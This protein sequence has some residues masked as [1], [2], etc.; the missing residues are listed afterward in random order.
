MDWIWSEYTTSPD[1]AAGMQSLNQMCSA[2]TKHVLLPTHI[3]LLRVLINVVPQL[4]HFLNLA[5]RDAGLS[6]VQDFCQTELQLL[7][8]STGSDVATQ[9]QIVWN[10]IHL[11]DKVYIAMVDMKSLWNRHLIHILGRERPLQMRQIVMLLPPSLRIKL[12]ANFLRSYGILVLLPAANAQE[13]EHQ[14]IRHLDC[15]ARMCTDVSDV[16]SQQ[17]R[18]DKHTRSY[19]RS[20]ADCVDTG[21]LVSLQVPRRAAHDRTAAAPDRVSQH[22]HER[23]AAHAPRFPSP[24]PK[25]APACLRANV[26]GPSTS[27]DNLV[28]AYHQASTSGW[29]LS[30]RAA[31]IASKRLLNSS[32]IEHR[33]GDSSSSYFGQ[34]RLD[35][36]LFASTEEVVLEMQQLL[37]AVFAP[38]ERRPGC[39]LVDPQGVLMG[40]L[41][42][43]SCVEELQVAWKGLRERLNI[44]QRRFFQYSDCVTHRASPAELDTGNPSISAHNSIAHTDLPDGHEPG[45]PKDSGKGAFPCS[46]NS[47]HLRS[48]GP[49]AQAGMLPGPCQATPETALSSAV[50]DTAEACIR[51]LRAVNADSDGPI[52]PESRSRDHVVLAV[53][54]SRY[55]K[56]FAKDHAK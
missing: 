24:T 29:S 15:H 53:C 44:A 34:V 13:T 51:A 19:S 32:D 41:R 2:L 50:D 22:M 30:S 18:G 5:L 6:G 7:T 20:P 37:T 36:L 8:C 21:G 48:R 23:Q 33:R 26:S 46:R 45:G 43:A 3:V 12:P 40:I 38:T 47:E 27:M 25:V 9:N 17:E 4:G 56:S 28:M 42:G 16:V 10:W 55:G 31:R 14:R 1:P 52:I 54:N 49:S 11:I 35:Q 39:F